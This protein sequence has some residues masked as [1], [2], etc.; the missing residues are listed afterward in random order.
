MAKRTLANLKPE[1][2]AGKK[3]LVRVDF[4]V[5]QAENGAITD[6]TRIRAALPTIDYLRKSGAKSILVTHL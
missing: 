4:N 1:D 2:L 5:P 6:D 3:V